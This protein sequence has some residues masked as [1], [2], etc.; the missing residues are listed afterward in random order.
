MLRLLKH[1]NI[2]LT[3]PRLNDAPHIVPLLSDERVYTWLSS[4][5]HP[6]SLEDALW[7]LNRVIPH[8]DAIL[9]LLDA[10]KDNPEKITV[11]RPP[12]QII[13]EL[14]DDG[15]DVFLGD[16]T[17]DLAGQWWELEG[18]G[19]VSQPEKPLRGEQPDIWTIGD[20]LAPSHHRRGIMS[21]ALTT[22][23]TQWAIPR[24]GVQKMVVTTLKGN[25]GSVGV[26]KKCGCVFRKTIEDAIEVRGERKGVHVLEWNLQEYNGCL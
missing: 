1:D 16:L 22:L 17:L 15:S 4:V 25:E 9:A 10:S 14:K 21:D 2:V 24:M 13:R 7:W 5:P 20:Y 6:Y 18:T 26:F 8:S 3:P 23:L 12:V 11:D 19:L